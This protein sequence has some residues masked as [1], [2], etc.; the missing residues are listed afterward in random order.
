MPARCLVEESAKAK[1]G[2]TGAPARGLASMPDVRLFPWGPRTPGVSVLRGTS[3]S[4]ETSFALA[5]EQHFCLIL[6]IKNKSLRPTWIQGGEQSPPLNGRV[7]IF[8]PPAHAFQT[9]GL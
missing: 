4:W 5:S 8:S 1:L 9:Q 2:L 7:A 3:G 6:L